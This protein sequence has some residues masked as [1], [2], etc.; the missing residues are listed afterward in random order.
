MSLNYKSMQCG[1]LTTGYKHFAPLLLEIL[2]NLTEN[3]NFSL[4]FF[5]IF[6]LKLTES[7]STEIFACYQ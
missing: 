4:K 1:P 6:S 3:S 2:S 5:L 7:L